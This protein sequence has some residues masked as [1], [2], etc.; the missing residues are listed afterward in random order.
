ME[1]INQTASSLATA[2]NNTSRIT[3][4]TNQAIRIQQEAIAHVSESMTDMAG[5]VTLIASNAGIASRA[6][7]DAR[8]IAN[9][10][11][12]VVLD[13]TKSIDQL[14]ED[15][16]QA[17]QVINH[18][19][20]QSNNI[21]SIVN[22]I[23]QIS[24]QTNLLALNAA[25]EAARA[26]EHGRGFAVVAEEVRALASKTQL[27]TEEIQNMIRG[28]QTEITS[29]SSAM[30]RSRSQA[31]KT[32][33]LSSEA[34]NALTQI[35]ESIDNIYSLN[36]E[37]AQ[38]SQDISTKAQDID[39]NI[40]SINHSV[41]HTIDNSMKSTSE[42]GDL[43]QLSLLLHSLISQFKIAEDV[44]EEITHASHHDDSVELF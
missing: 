19:A 18:L 39:T 31:Q 40:I 38:A 7:T 8:D 3:A 17:E 35:T 41:E 34:G 11:Y 12:A 23:T 6:A 43:A 13:A 30:E 24:D 9:T 33:T 25:I 44:V 21:G 27:A 26:G 16:I 42:N 15:T 4:D 32:V 1:Q 37:I 29:A 36:T 20:E 5:R 22:S 10:G 2:S 14:T 28:I